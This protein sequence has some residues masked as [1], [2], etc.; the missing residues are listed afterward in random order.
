MDATEA[1]TAAV[2]EEWN[3][4]RVERLGEAPS[5]LGCGD[6]HWLAR[7]P[8]C[9]GDLLCCPNRRGRCERKKDASRCPS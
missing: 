9:C 1:V 7:E 5:C 3:G 6:S 2:T 8:R 4:G